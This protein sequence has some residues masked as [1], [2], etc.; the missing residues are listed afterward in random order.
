MFHHNY[1]QDTTDHSQGVGLAFD[2]Q[3]EDVKI[4]QTIN[5]LKQNYV[6]WLHWEGLLA[7]Q[8]Q[9]ILYVES[10]QCFIHNCRNM[11]LRYKTNMATLIKQT[12][13]LTQYF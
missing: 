11:Y 4:I 5:I 10:K 13:T 7:V 2:H 1:I 9:G 8:Q 12:F 6:F 3:M